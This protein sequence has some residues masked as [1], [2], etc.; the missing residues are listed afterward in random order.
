M[1]LRRP[2]AGWHSPLAAVARDA[3][4]TV[5]HFSGIQDNVKRCQARSAA[6]SSRAGRQDSSSTLISTWPT[7]P[8]AQAQPQISVALEALTVAS[9]AGAT[10]T[11]C[12]AIAQ[13]GTVRPPLD[14]VRTV[15]TGHHEARGKSVLGLK[16]L[17]IHFIS[18]QNVRPY[19]IDGHILDIGV[20]ADA[21]EIAMVRAGRPHKSTSRM[22]LAFSKNVG[23]AR[24]GPGDV[25]NALR[26]LGY[27][28]SGLP[29]HWCTLVTDTFSY[30]MR[31]ENERVRGRT[32]SPSIANDQSSR[33]M[34]GNPR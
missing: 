18:N 12:G 10:I 14:T 16:W 1:A 31:S 21:G 9:G 15:E 4:V 11:D 8:S 32:T 28:A 34:R 3:S 19:A 27:G 7:P 29:A 2:D 5:P 6:G 13:T 33:A 23:E 30:R 25:A 24:A 20:D 22:R 17:A 26:R